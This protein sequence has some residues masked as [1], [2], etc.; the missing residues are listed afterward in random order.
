MSRL[1]LTLMC[2][3]MPL[4]WKRNLLDAKLIILTSVVY[5]PEQLYPSP[6][7]PTARTAFLLDPALIRAARAIY[8]TYYSVHP[9]RPDLPIGVAI[10]RQS[11]R[12][13]LIFGSK[14]IL[15]P[16]ECFVPF[17]QIESEIV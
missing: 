8:L 14:P 3:A 15:L 10:H 4:Q 2:S 9:D 7:Y 12:G 6:A 13:K 16:K 11:Y 1:K 5:F 17:Q